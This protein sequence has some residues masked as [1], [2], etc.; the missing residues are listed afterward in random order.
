M[1]KSKS[2]HR[3]P[4]TDLMSMAERELAAFVGAVTALCG[5]E[6]ARLSAE[7]WLDEL[8]LMDSVPES[9]TPDWRL[10]TVAAT[11]RRAHRLIVAL[12]QETLLV[13]SSD[14]KISPIPSSNCFSSTLL[15]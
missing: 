14:T 9:T 15:V 6:E 7:D 11:A 4:C 5:P 12:H 3:P 2:L 13:T 1:N 8:E 10:I